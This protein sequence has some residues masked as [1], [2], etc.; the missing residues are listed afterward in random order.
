MKN[1]GQQELY[2]R[3]WWWKKR[4]GVYPELPSVSEIE[5]FSPFSQFLYSVKFTYPFNF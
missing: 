2:T 3:N 1:F 4:A 5:D